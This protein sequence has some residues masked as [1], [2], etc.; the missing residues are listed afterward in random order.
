MIFSRGRKAAGAPPPRPR[1]PLV[2][3]ETRDLLFAEK[4]GKT[5]GQW[6]VNLHHLGSDLGDEPGRGEGDVALLDIRDLADEVFSQ[7]YALRTR[8]P[9]VEVVLINRPDNVV[10]SIAGMKAGAV[11]EV[12]VPFDTGLL[13]GIITAACGRREAARVK[14]KKKPLMTRFS[15][16]MMAATFAQAGDFEGALDLIEGPGPPSTENPASTKKSGG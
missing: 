5:L 8:F 11:D 12:I 14:Q 2:L 1:S 9:G 6:G 4:I 13:Q 16:A 7:V 3:I 15:E 10:A